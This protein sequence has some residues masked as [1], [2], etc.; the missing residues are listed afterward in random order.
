VALATWA[1]MVP[2]AKTTLGLSEGRLGA[3]LLAF[4][5]GT[6]AATLGARTLLGRYGSRV[7][8]R[9]AGPA[10]CVMLPLLALA[11]SA[12]ALAVLLF[13]FG[14]LVGLAGVASNAPA[15]AVQELTGRPIMSGF[16]A[17]FSIGGLIGAALG[18]FLL[19]RGVPVVVCAG[20]AAAG[21]AVLDITV[22]RGLVADVQP[23]AAG[24]ARRGIPPAAVLLVGV[25]TLCMYLAE[26]AVLDW[27]AV[28]LHEARDYSVS[29]AALGY[30]AFSIAMATGRLLGDQVVARLGAVSVVR[31]GALLAAAGVA[32]LVWAPWGPAGLV[33]CALIGLGASN[34]VPTLIT[35]SALVSDLPT[36]AAV[37]TVVAMGTCGLIAGPA[38][39]GF[40]AQATSLS[41]ALSVLAGLLLLV[42]LVAPAVRRRPA[43]G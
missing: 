7:A 33:G 37:A 30:A 21:L 28:F 6:I 31:F 16:H 23:E 36:G 27:G 20:V 24:E 42:G 10:V 8:L 19:G 29:A 32:V 5:F 38:I 13:V 34:V 22:A 17:Q 39:I 2:F 4:G 15:G 41:V 9:I 18:S 11:P 25:M 35:A 40:A 12:V 3:I 14:A 1:A 43:A 26:G